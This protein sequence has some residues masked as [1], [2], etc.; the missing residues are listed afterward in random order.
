VNRST[1][2]PAR[3]LPFRARSARY[4]CLARPLLHPCA[5]SA[6]LELLRT[7]LGVDVQARQVSERVWEM[8]VP[9]RPS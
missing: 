9:A 3:P 8:A 5:S 2:G 4:R 1:A 6:R 7:F